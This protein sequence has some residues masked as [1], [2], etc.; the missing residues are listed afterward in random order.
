[1]DHMSRSHDFFQEKLQS[2]GSGDA[3]PFEFQALDALLNNLV[4]NAVINAVMVTLS[5]LVCGT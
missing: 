2:A 5:I 4:N 1:M 3:M